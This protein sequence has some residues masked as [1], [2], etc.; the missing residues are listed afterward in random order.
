LLRTFQNK[1]RVWSIERRGKTLTIRHGKA[2][3]KQQ[4]RYRKLYSDYHAER[5]LRKEVDRKLREGYRETTPPGSMPPL[6]DTGQALEQAV[7][8]DPGD[9][10]A[11]MA[12]ADWLSE[13][14][15]AK[16]QTWGEFIRTQLAL[17]TADLP[18]GQR[19]ALQQRTNELTDSNERDWL[20][21]PLAQ[22]LLGLRPNLLPRQFQAEGDF[23]RT[24]ARGWLD[25]L[26][27]PWL[28]V[29]IAKILAGADSLRLL[30]EL[31]ILDM[32]ARGDPFIPLAGA[33]NL[34][35]IRVLALE[36]CGGRASPAP[37]VGSLPRLE[38][39]RLV[40][41][42]ADSRGLLML[43]GLANLRTL[44][45]AGLEP[46]P[47]ND[48]AASPVLGQ[49]RRLSLNGIELA[50]ND[51][52]FDV[53]AVPLDEVGRALHSRHLTSLAEVTVN[54]FVNGDQGCEQIV[55]SGVLGRLETLDLSYGDLSDE[56]ARILAGCPDLP[57]L[58]KLVVAANILTR[59]GVQL[60]RDTGVPM[61][62]R[63]PQGYNP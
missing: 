60:L 51:L 20:G 19:K 28:N 61:P 22:V 42:A 43:P 30:R 26:V 21:E 2:A 52:D 29:P 39:L 41:M 62:G 37:L 25:T 16:L 40:T 53:P 34:A 46:Y 8:A 14:A 55:R 27:V 57:R 4:A 35:N 23:P 18:A 5:E 58:K 54:V 32:P 36:G 38:E 45:L 49:L 59:R 3:G 24:F 10:A 63:Q 12:L 44:G 31:V 33:A 17:E 47:L 7:V 48:L 1:D 11:H 6:D 50:A 9:R 15:D 56:G 13:Q